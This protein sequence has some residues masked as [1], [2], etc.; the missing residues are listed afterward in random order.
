MN[1]S[2]ESKGKTPT[3]G[4]EDRDG[5]GREIGSES[6]GDAVSEIKEEGISLVV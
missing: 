3:R 5:T 2:N 4:Q 6:G 1:E